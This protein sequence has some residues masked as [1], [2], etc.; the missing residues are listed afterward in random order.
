MLFV[1]RTVSTTSAVGAL[2]F[3]CTSWSHLTLNGPAS[4]EHF[5]PTYGNNT[6]TIL[7]IY[8]SFFF[9]LLGAIGLLFISSA[10]TM[11]VPF[12]MGKIIDI[13]YTSSQN[14]AQMVDTLT[15]VCKILCG[16]FL[17]GGTANSGR[18]YLIQIS[19]KKL[20]VFSASVFWPLSVYI[21]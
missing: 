2:L 10:V 1:M 5:S 20:K 19:G 14:P 11:S 9:F 13:I 4:W 16:V 3:W 8:S 15:Y 7:A 12:C 17:L 18:V 21:K 6:E